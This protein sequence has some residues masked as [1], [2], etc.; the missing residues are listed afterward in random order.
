ML[1]Y[2]DEDDFPNI[3]GSWSEKLHHEDKERSVNAL[4]A[5]MLDTTGKTPFNIEY[6]QLTKSGEYR[7]YQ[8]FG[9]TL[10]GKEGEPL[11]SAGAIKDITKEKKMIEELFK[12]KSQ[13]EASLGNNLPDSTLFR[14]VYEI[15]TEKY[16]YEYVNAKWEEITGLKPELVYQN[17]ELFF[18]NV[19]PNDIQYFMDAIHESRDKLTNLNVEVRFNN[20]GETMWLL[21]TGH[22][23]IRGYNKVVWDGIIRNIT[24]RKAD[25]LELIIAKERAEESDKLKSAFLANMSHEIRTPLN[26]IVGILQIIKT[27]NLHPEYYEHIEIASTSSKQLIK[28]VSDILDIS[29]IEA[30]QMTI[31]TVE[32]DV[33]EMIN[34]M[35]SLYLK[36]I[37]SKGNKANIELI[38]DDSNFVVPCVINND[39]TRLKQVLSNLI[40]NAIKYTPKG[41]VSFGYKINDSGMIEFAIN[42]S[43]IG[44]TKHFVD[45]IFERFRQAELSPTRQYGGT[46]LG[47]S[48]SSE[49]VHL[50]GGSMWVE[51]TEEVGTSIYF[52]IPYK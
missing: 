22:P 3:L 33:N 23:Y 43:G 39:E 47:L 12:S 50:M 52:T 42:D 40:D 10:R 27:E 4:G 32:I 26:A 36:V 34:E 13:L 51:S 19:H 25:D 45:V 29:K 37:Q 46:G 41:F 38:L 7:Y 5:H 48:I 9:E 16:S 2:E 24:K 30:K 31:S 14:A 20:K 1:E 11:R 15:E 44:M 49:L 6:R 21:V 18:D 17:L 35:Y 8:A 28:I